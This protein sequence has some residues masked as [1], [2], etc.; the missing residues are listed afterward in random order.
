MTAVYCCITCQMSHLSTSQSNG[1][2][3]AI[4]RNACTAARSRAQ[5]DQWA[6]YSAN[7]KYRLHTLQFYHCFRALPPSTAVGLLR[8]QEVGIQLEETFQLKIL[9]SNGTDPV[10]LR[11]SWN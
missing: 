7:H 5:P 3:P 10:T 6:S 9:T 4:Q 8:L 1:A 11:L 2:I